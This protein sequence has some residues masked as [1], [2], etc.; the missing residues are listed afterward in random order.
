M[1]SAN[2]YITCFTQVIC[3]LAEKNQ[4]IYILPEIYFT[5]LYRLPEIPRMVLTSI[6]NSYIIWVTFYIMPQI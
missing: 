5:N 4:L 6:F 1:F 2:M 3:I